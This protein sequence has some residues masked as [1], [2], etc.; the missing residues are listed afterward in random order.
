M[1]LKYRIKFWN[2]KI[3]GSF[4]RTFMELKFCNSKSFNISIKF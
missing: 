3:G 4:N 1:E 2:N